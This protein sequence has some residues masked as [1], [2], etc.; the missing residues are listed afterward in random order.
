[1][2]TNY[3][4]V[5]P[6]LLR[7]VF[8]VEP[9]EGAEWASHVCRDGAAPILLHDGDGGRDCVMGT[10]GLVSREEIK[11]RNKEMEKR[12]GQPPKLKDYATMNARSEGVAERAA[13]KGPWRNAQY[14]LIPAVAFDEPNYEAGPK[15]VWYRIRPA[16]EP[17]FGIAGLWQRWPNDTFSFTMLTVNAEGHSVMGRMHKPAD[18]K[19]SIVLVPPTQ[20]DDWLQ[21]DNPDLA[22]TFMT[23]YPAEKMLAAPA[24]RLVE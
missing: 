14:C 13:F 23:L 5:Q 16:G 21:C 22:R 20:W 18:E 19:R 9:P 11:R 3:A 6:Q 4:P 1:M 8:L 2:C 15:C 12:T 24:L 17:A 7:D 10:F